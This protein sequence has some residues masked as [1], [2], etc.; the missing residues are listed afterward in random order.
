[1]G[2][3]LSKLKR[4]FTGEPS[5]SEAVQYILLAA[6]R[7]RAKLKIEL[8]DHLGDQPRIMSATILK[9]RKNDFV[10]SQPMIDGRKHAMV[11]GESL[12]LSLLCTAGHLTGQSKA[13]GR[14]RVAAKDDP[15]P[16][17]GQAPPESVGGDG[18]R[19]RGIVYG[20][21]LSLPKFFESE[22]RS[23]ERIPISQDLDIEAELH[24]PSHHEP[25]R[26][27]VKNISRGGLR[28]R[29]HNA[30]GKLSKGQRVYLKVELPAPIGLITE[31]V[32][33]AHL[34]PADDDVHLMVGVAFSRRI[35]ALHTF[36]E[37]NEQTQLVSRRKG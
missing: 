22:S 37:Q 35:E 28:I 8:L 36:L 10:I 21:R 11:K 20:Y 27:V 9:V 18:S 31:M 25:V 16:A 29:S 1:M 32:R 15:P 6:H 2:A 34:A 23:E 12:R 24:S 7:E 13:R 4:A 17:T 14:I 5:D 3:F 26:G 30:K 19:G 33:V